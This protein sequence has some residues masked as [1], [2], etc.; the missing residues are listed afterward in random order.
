MADRR[1]KLLQSTLTIGNFGIEQV[2]MSAVER[3]AIQVLVSGVSDCHRS[4]CQHIFNTPVEA[5]LF[6]LGLAKG[7]LDGIQDGADTRAVGANVPIGR[8]GLEMPVVPP[9]CEEI[10]SSSPQE[11]LKHRSVSGPSRGFR[12]PGFDVRATNVGTKH[13]GQYGILARFGI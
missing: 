5:R 13:A 8:P 10:V 7:M 3:F 4:A 1:R 11:K 6:L 2:L 9:A 12:R